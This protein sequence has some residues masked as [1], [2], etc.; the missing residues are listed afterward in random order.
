M[1]KKPGIS[2]GAA[3]SRRATPKSIRK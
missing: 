3:A 1:T 2:D